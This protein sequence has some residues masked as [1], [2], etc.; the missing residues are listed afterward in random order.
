MRMAFGLAG[1]LVT[2][3]VMVWIWHEVEGPDIQ[4]SLTAQKKV[5]TTLNQL[6]GQDNNGI[7]VEDSYKVFADSRDDGKLLDLQVTEVMPGGPMDAKYGLRAN[8]VII[9]AI[10]GHTVRTDFAGLNSQEEGTDAIR[11]AYTTGGQLVVERGNAKLTLPLSPTPVAPAQPNNPNTLS[12]NAQK[13]E[14]QQEGKTDHT[15][16][17]TMDRIKL[18]ALPGF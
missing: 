15:E 2:L 17:G 8:D 3:G 11:D 10:D 1:L 14:Q 12:A 13:T 4:V 9:A 18:H 7:R 16:D 6:N 5:D